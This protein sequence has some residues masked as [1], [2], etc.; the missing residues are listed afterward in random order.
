MSL[1]IFSRDL[2]RSP[3]MLVVIGLT[4]LQALSGCGGGGGSAPPP[5][6]TTVAVSGTVDDGTENSPIGSATCSLRDLDGLRRGSNVT[7]DADGNY[8]VRLDPD[9]EGFLTC[10]HPTIDRLTLVTF[11]STVGAEAGDQIADEAVTPATTVVA[12]ILQSENPTDHSSRKSELLDDIENETDPGLNQLVSASTRLFKRML[13]EEINVD[14]GGGEGGAGG[15]G[16]VG[17]GAGDGGDRS[18][19][20][21]ALCEFIV[22]EDNDLTNGKVLHD[23]ALTDFFE[24]GQLDRPDLAAIVAEL[25]DEFQH[26]RQELA[27]AYATYFGSDG[28]GTA[29]ADIT[30]SEGNYFIEIPPN[31]SGF[32]R[33]TPPDEEQAG[34]VLATFIPAQAEGQDPAENEDVNPAMTL[35]SVDIARKLSGDLLASVR[36]NYIADV[37]EIGDIRINVVNENTPDEEITGYEFNTTPTNDDVGPMAFSASAL[38]L[39]YF[40]NDINNDY[41]ATLKRFLSDPDLGDGELQSLIN[42]PDNELQ[43]LDAS[44]NAAA[45]AL[46][47]GFSHASERARLKVTVVDAENPE[48]GAIGGATVRVL[49]DDGFGNL[50]I[51][52]CDDPD[53]DG[54]SGITE[55][56]QYESNFEGDAVLFILR[57]GSRDLDPDNNETSPTTVTVEVEKEGFEIQRVETQVLE[58]ATVSLNVEL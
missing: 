6:E 17:G 58:L 13:E 43:V 20:V 30:D 37:R 42:L 55:G 40:K 35:F 2:Y 27:D 8:T 53:E 15:G 39:S 10:R 31:V 45:G 24:D 50:L 29:Y 7:A 5:P 52:T 9:V 57:P 23:A 4:F 44:A 41:L 36:E 28:I 47:T 51:A 14:F 26:H 18:P 12:R 22:S 56:C 49:V 34:L 25:N 21:G 3:L 38:Y 48:E 32:V 16:G 11:I 1:G 46:N 54:N 33:C 19:I